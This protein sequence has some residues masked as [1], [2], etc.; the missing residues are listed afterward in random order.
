MT[1]IVS[2]IQVVCIA[3]LTTSGGRI[4]IKR[5]HRQKAGGPLARMVKHIPTPPI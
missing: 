3:A 1:E 5:T 4:K 2:T